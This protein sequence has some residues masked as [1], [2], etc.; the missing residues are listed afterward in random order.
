VCVS[1]A[2]PAFLQRAITHFKAQTYPNKDL[3]VLYEGSASFDCRSNDDAIKLVRIPDGSNLSL[4]ERRNISIQHCTGEYFCQWDDDDWYHNRRIELQMAALEQ[5]GMPSCVLRRLILYDGKTQRAYLS[6]ERR[7]EG[8]LLC[9]VSLITESFRYPHVNRSEDNS[10]VVSL[11]GRDYVHTLAA[12]FLY[13]YFYH[14]GNTWDQSHFEQL[15]QAGYPLDE[16]ANEIFRRLFSD[17]GYADAS[18]K[19]ERLNLQVPTR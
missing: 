15:F 3:V 12:P 14:G 4:G 8:T 11:V 10:L 6:S 13:G 5:S 16:K 17:D 19:I 7:W 1:K 9:R 18:E 2:R